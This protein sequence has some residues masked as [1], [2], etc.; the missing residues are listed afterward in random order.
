MVFIKSALYTKL[1]LGN[2]ETGF[3]H[4]IRFDSIRFI[5]I[6]ST[7][8]YELGSLILHLFENKNE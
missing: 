4:S 5:L 2:N 3:I 6:I 8:W 1:L 7:T